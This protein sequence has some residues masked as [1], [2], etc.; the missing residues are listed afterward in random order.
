MTTR[1]RPTKFTPD[2]TQKII[3]A[4]RGGNYRSTACQYAGIN[5]QT[6]LNWLTIAKGPDAPPEYVDFLEAVEKAEAD[7]EVARVALIAKASQ[8]VMDEDGEL[9]AKGS[10][11][12]AA[13]HLER[14]HPERWGRREASK[15]EISGPDGGPISVQAA[16]GVDQESISGLLMS[17]A[18]R[19]RDEQVAELMESQSDGWVDEVER[20]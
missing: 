9:V 2:R 15:V 14:S 4:L 17:L 6:F 1:G 3:D 7:A 16:L 12:A 5:Y 19:Q 18:S 8:D 11:Q 13:W 10:W 20:D